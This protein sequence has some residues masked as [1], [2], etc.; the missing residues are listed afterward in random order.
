M[1]PDVSE[2]AD[3]VA[4]ACPGLYDRLAELRD[5]VHAA[6]LSAVGELGCVDDLDAAV[7]LNPVSVGPGNHVLVVP[8]SVRMV[9]PR[10]AKLAAVGPAR[11]RVAALV[12]VVFEGFPV[13]A[14]EGDHL[15]LPSAEE[16]DR[17]AKFVSS[18][19]WCV[20]CAVMDAVRAG[21]L[22]SGV[23]VGDDI[24]IENLLMEDSGGGQATVSLRVAW[25]QP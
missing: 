10:N 9:R 22:L 12:A 16:Y 8:E 17:A 20:M 1:I 7:V 25:T 21:N 3:E 6:V 2:C 5:V 13:A 24:E 23:E 4:V 14:V 19:G 11:V 15:L 18:V